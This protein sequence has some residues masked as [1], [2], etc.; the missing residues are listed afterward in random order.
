MRL[1]SNIL[2]CEFSYRTLLRI[3]CLLIAC[4]HVVAFPCSQ[5]TKQPDRWATAS[6]NGLVR[7]AH[8]FYESDSGERA[9][10]AALDR[11]ANALRRC[12]LDQDEAFVARYREFVEYVRLLSLTPL[13]DHELGFTV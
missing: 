9:Y 3:F 1:R 7:T 6:I 8:G 11:S 10:D 4:S 5:I 13:P 2:G 12:Q